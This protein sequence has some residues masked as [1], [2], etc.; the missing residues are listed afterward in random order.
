MA[1]AAELT[2]D[3]ERQQLEAAAAAVLVAAAVTT[4]Q[5]QV[6]L[7]KALLAVQVWL[8]IALEL[9]AAVVAAAVVA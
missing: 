7:I 4:P 1:A 3:L 6:L 8:E 9:G 2:P 5:L